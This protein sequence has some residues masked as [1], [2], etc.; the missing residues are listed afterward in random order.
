MSITST[1]VHRAEIRFHEAQDVLHPYVG[2]F[3]IVTAERRAAIRVVPDGT[4]SISIQVQEGQRSLVPLACREEGWPRAGD[5]SR[6][7]RAR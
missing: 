7:R 2:C 4:T 3:W 6:F 1:L 5:V